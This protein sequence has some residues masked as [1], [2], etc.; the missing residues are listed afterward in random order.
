MVDF[1]GNIEFEFVLLS[2]WGPINNSMLTRIVVSL[3]VN[4]AHEKLLVRENEQL[5]APLTIVRSP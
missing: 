4:I 1:Y 2:H 5:V 3:L